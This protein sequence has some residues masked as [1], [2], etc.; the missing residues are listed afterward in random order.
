VRLAD[1]Y[2][3]LELA[4]RRRS[5]RAYAAAKLALRRR[6]AALTDA[7]RRLHRLGFRLT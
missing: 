5:R 6:Q 3:S 1:S 7:L 2:R 4:A